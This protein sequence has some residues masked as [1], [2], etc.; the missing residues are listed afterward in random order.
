VH[1][2]EQAVEPLRS[3]LSAPEL[4]RLV[5]AL[6]V[7]I[8]FEAMIVL[9]DVRG[10]ADD[11]AADLSVAMARALVDQAMADQALD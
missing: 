8:G 11:D 9:R 5:S 7:I 6:S 3:R 10:L 4:D 1:W 2:I